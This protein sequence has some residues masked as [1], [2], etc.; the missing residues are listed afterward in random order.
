MLAVDLNKDSR[1]GGE[2]RGRVQSSEMAWA[3]LEHPPDVDYAPPFAEEKTTGRKK[4]KIC[5]GVIDVLASPH[6][7]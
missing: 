4:Y 2:H 6:G 1:G 3:W 5:P 7:K